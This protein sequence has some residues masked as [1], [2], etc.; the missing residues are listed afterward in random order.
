MKIRN[1]KLSKRTLALLAA[2]ALLFGGGGFAG[3]K[4]AL[5]YFSEDYTA[6]FELD[7][8]STT[9]RYTWLR[10]KTMYAAV[11]MRASTQSTGQTTR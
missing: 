7:H 8:N 9:C 6:A 4:A 2:T 10:M 11:K 1:T 5:T 3:T